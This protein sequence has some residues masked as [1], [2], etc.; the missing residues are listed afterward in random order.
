MKKARNIIFVI[1]ALAFV[2][3]CNTAVFATVTGPEA[4]GVQDILA[5][6][7][8]DDFAKYAPISTVSIDFSKITAEDVR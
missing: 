2:C 3:S 1:M 6:G 7:S 8:V 5:S 4:N